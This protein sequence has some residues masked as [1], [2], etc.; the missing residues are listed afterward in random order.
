MCLKY[1]R[2]AAQG[3]VA[4]VLVS[5]SSAQATRRKPKPRASYICACRGHEKGE[6]AASEC[7]LLCNDF[8]R[9]GYNKI[10]VDPSVRLAYNHKDAK[11]VHKAQFV[12]G[13]RMTDWADVQSSPGIDWS[14]TPHRPYS[15]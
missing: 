14:L 3:K 1:N 5:L 11:D 15:K 12:R 4:V 10:V 9:L 2:A 8:Q 6:C 7:T 13:V